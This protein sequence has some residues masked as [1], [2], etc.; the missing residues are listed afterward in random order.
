MGKKHG[1]VVTI[2]EGLLIQEHHVKPK[3]CVG[4]KQSLHSF[5]LNETMVLNRVN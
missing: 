2:G 1:R 5:T 4:K 3:R